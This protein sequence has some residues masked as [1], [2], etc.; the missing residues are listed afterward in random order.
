MVPGVN[1]RNGCPR[2]PQCARV[3]VSVMARGRVAIF[4]VPGEIGHQH[5]ATVTIAAVYRATVADLH[6]DEGMTEGAAAAVT[7]DP[8]LGDADFLGGQFGGTG[9]GNGMTRRHF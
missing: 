9:D 3:L 4:I 8:V 2:A 5:E 6:I 1:S 7:G